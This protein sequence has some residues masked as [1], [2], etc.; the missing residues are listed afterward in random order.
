MHLYT[1]H[2]CDSKNNGALAVDGPERSMDPNFDQSHRVDVV[3]LGAGSPTKSSWVGNRW[4]LW[5]QS[6]LPVLASHSC[7]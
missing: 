6:P 7:A 1:S 4:D 3:S 2:G 5:G